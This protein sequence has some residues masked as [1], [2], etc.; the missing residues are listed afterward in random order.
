MLP[1]LPI[2]PTR[3]KGPLGINENGLT[4]IDHYYINIIFVERNL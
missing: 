1:K 3:D 4:R 2:V